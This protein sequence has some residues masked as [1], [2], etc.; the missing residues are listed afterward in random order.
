MRME[1]YF[2][3]VVIASTEG[4][5]QSVI[6]KKRTDSHGHKCPRNDTVN[7]TN[8][9]L[10]SSLNNASKAPLPKGGWQKSLI[11]D[12]GIY[13]FRQYPPLKLTKIVNFFPPL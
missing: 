3:T 5:W 2:V 13:K 10:S 8:S 4:A 12:W 7:E 6:P 1:N 11:F 9:D